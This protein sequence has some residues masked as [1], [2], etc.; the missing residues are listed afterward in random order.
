MLERR[1]DYIYTKDVL[2]TMAVAFVADSQT[3]EPVPAT[4]PFNVY[5]FVSGEFLSRKK[6]LYDLYGC[7]CGSNRTH[8]LQW[9]RELLFLS[10][11]RRQYVIIIKT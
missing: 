9:T 5:D 8:V 10:G 1:R 11:M 4:K 3:S 2:F 6:A 7:I